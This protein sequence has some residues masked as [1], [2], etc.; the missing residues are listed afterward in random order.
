MSTHEPPHRLF[1]GESTPPPTFRHPSHN[2]VDMADDRPC[3]RMSRS[4]VSDNHAHSWQGSGVAFVPDA[5]TPVGGLNTTVTLPC[6][7][8]PRAP[9]CHAQV[10]VTWLQRKTDTSGPCREGSCLG[11]H[12]GGGAGAP[13]PFYQLIM[14]HATPTCN[15]LFED[16]TSITVA[17]NDRHRNGHRAV[18][19]IEE[20]GCQHR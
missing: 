11:I 19:Y 12:R 4:F 9:P 5:H 6:R 16:T 18:T 3:C 13:T 20:L 17:G 1:F 8:H 2:Q 10:L 15:T 7:S 14:I